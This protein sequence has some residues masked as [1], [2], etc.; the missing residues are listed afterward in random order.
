ML[1]NIIFGPSLLEKKIDPTIFFRNVT[2]YPATTAQFFGELLLL[3]M[4][5]P[6]KKSYLIFLYEVNIT[7]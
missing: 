2:L 3:L 7:I 4:G 5:V 6:F 1:Y